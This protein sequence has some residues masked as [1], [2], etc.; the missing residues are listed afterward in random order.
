MSRGAPASHDGPER[1]SQPAGIGEDGVRVEA[2]GRDPYDADRVPG[3]VTMTVPRRLVRY[4]NDPTTTARS[5]VSISSITS[6]GSAVTGV[7]TAVGD[8]GEHDGGITGAQGD[9]GVVHIVDPAAAHDQRHPS[10]DRWRHQIGAGDHRER[11]LGPCDVGVAFDPC[12]AGVGERVDP[13]VGPGT[14]DPPPPWVRDR[15]STPRPR[16]FGPAAGADRPTVRARR[17][18]ARSRSPP[19]PSVRPDPWGHAAH[20]S[21][22]STRRVSAVW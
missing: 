10:L 17:R 6:C 3:S 2:V 8:E 21:T 19:R 16:R 11:R 20:W 13:R 18:C 7:A 9:P 1:S 15:A 4:R 5:E 22:S 14:D 12:E